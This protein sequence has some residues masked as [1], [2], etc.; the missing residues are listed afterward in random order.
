MDWKKVSNKHYDQV[1]ALIFDAKDEEK[2]WADLWTRKLASSTDPESSE[3]M[4]GRIR[5]SQEFVEVL[6]A[7]LEFIQTNRVDS[8]RK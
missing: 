2:D 1:L 5:D 8:R 6:D 7:L 3:K 4:N